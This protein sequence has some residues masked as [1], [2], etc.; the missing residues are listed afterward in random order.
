MIARK[1]EFY[2]G[3]GMM[4]GFVLIFVFIFLPLFNG[5]NGIDF[6]DNL[7]NSI[8]KQSA[9]FIPAL[10]K[11]IAGSLSD[12]KIAVTLELPD[13]K[14][15]RQ[16]IPLFT[17]AG[18]TAAADGTSL[19]VEGE[20]KGILANCLKDADALFH[21][22]SDAMRTKYAMDGRV[23]LYNW[24]L[25]LKAMGK[26]LNAQGEFKLAKTNNAVMTRAVECAY[27]YYKVVPQNMI[28]CW[29]VATFALVFYVCYTLWYGYAILFLFEGWGLKISH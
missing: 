29:G 12:K 22:R 24:W 2:G 6:L 28:D 15:A 8:S 26:A 4:A 3:L 18:A 9:Y 21:N 5:K 17:A 7:F 10:E 20:M 16:S 23:V 1:K 13:E 19:R 27:N 11:N 14:A 25:C